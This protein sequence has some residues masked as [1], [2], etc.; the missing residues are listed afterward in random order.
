[1]KH[2]GLKNLKIKDVKTSITISL[3]VAICLLANPTWG[4]LPLDKHVANATRSLSQLLDVDP[5]EIKVVKADIV[6]WRN[7]ALGCPNP[8]LGYM[9][10]ITP[11]VRVILTLA[12]NNYFYH[13]D[14]NSVFLCDSDNREEP[15]KIDSHTH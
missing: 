14:T 1:M 12:D 4:S 9:Q 11:G 13:G 7:S 3:L 2:I 5:T 6:Q 10:M 8:Q 15:F